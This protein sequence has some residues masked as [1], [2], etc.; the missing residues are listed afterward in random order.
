MT[1][2]SVNLPRAG[3]PPKQCVHSIREAVLRETI[4]PKGVTVL[5]V[6][7]RHQTTVHKNKSS[8]KSTLEEDDK[9]NIWAFTLKCYR[10]SAY[11]NE[12]TASLQWNISDSS[13]FYRCVSEEGTTKLIKER[14]THTKSWRKSHIAIHKAPDWLPLFRFFQILHFMQCII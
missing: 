12:H 14:N 10:L 7:K 3:C 4:M 5:M 6:E 9:T 2:T 13:M 11:H 8:A 1:F